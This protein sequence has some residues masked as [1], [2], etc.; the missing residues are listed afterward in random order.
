MDY[1]KPPRKK[2]KFT[3]K[4][5]GFGTHYDEN[6]SKTFDSAIAEFFHKTGGILAEEY[7]SDT[8][9]ISA[10]VQ[11]LRNEGKLTT[12]SSIMFEDFDYYGNDIDPD[13]VNSYE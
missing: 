11:F 13:D 5:R 7:G 12:K 4:L 6:G 1:L 9:V 2:R 10:F 3:I 8:T